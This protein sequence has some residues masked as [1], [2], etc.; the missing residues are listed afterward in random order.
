V[1]LEEEI[2]GSTYR[3]VM[4]ITQVIIIVF[5]VVVE[6]LHNGVPGR[7]LVRKR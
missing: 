1:L 2:K 6:K 4:N 3:I 5:V 7:I